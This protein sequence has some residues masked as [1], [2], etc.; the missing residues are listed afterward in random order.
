M[1][2]EPQG[3][4]LLWTIRYYEQIST[5]TMTLLT[6]WVGLSITQLG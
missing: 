3:I 6:H 1:D 2:C 4:W 5:R